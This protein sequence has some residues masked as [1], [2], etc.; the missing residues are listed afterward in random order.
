MNRTMLLMSPARSPGS[1]AGHALGSTTMFP[2][3]SR[4]PSHQPSSIFTYAYPAFFRPDL[5]IASA[6]AFATS[7]LMVFENEFQ[8]DHPIGGR[9]IFASAGTCCARAFNLPTEI[10]KIAMRKPLTANH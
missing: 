9:E 1:S 6:C 5:T 8:D 3:V 2:C 10:P 4:S 7:E